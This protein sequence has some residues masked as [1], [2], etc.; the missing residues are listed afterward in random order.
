[1]YYYAHKLKSIKQGEASER[2]YPLL[3]LAIVVI[4]LSYLIS[5]DMSGDGSGD[6]GRESGSGEGGVDG[7]MVDDEVVPGRQ[8]ALSPIGCTLVNGTTP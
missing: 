2:G 6:F 7:T 5:V 3:F 1:M 4:N 8:V